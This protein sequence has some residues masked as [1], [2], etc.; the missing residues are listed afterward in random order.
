M[1]NPS[2]SEKLLKALSEFTLEDAF[3]LEELDRQYRALQRLH[4]AVGDNELFLKLVIVNAL[5]S[6]QLP[7]R[8][9]EYWETFAGFFSENPDLQR[10]EEF[11]RTYNNR[12]LSGKLRRLRRVLSLVE[13]LSRERLVQFCRN[14]GALLEYLSEGLKQ[15]KDAKT[16]VFAV[17]MFIYACRIA[18][19]KPIR[20]PFDIDI[21]LDVRLK[22]ISDRLEFWRTLAKRLGIPPLHLDALV[23]VTMGADKRFIENLPEDLKEKVLNLKRTLKELVP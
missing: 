10:F 18:T 5:M 20:A 22:K 11:I 14:P 16:L 13:N 15:P 6:Y 9:E 23:W 8:G 4:S 3:R 12:F 17:K 1:T 21:P 7:M 2:K 19:G